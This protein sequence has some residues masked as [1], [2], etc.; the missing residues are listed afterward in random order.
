MPASEFTHPNAFYEHM[1]PKIILRGLVVLLSL[2]AIGFLVKQTHL[3]D[4]L[5]QGWI[6]QEVRGKGLSGEI[7]FIAAGTLFTAVG[8]P[9]QVISFMGGYAFGF[10][11][12]TLLSLLATLLGCAASFY[13][14]RLLGRKLVARR[15]PGKIAHVDNFVRDY[16]VTMTL[17]IRLLPVGSNI[18][19]NL[20]GG[21]SSVPAMPFLFGSL[22]GYLPQ[23][24]IFALVGSGV[25]VDPTWRIGLGVVL[26]VGSAVLGVYLFRR[27]RHGRHFDE[28]LE[29]KL[30]ETG[31]EDAGL[32]VN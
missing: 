15:L 22:V 25:N 18:A 19:T 16:P 9:R 14:A 6:D 23:T 2:A 31:D 29:H 4:L 17:L 32:P 13:Y 12:G 30:G 20:A 26:F 5:N 7:L 3:G 24:F 1:N 11:Y 28:E 21:V 8:L 10:L 27:L